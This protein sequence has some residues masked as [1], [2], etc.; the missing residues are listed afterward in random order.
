M[1]GRSRRHHH[2]ALLVCTGRYSHGQQPRVITGTETRCL[3]LGA[4]WPVHLALCLTF[5]HLTPPHIALSRSMGSFQ[6]LLLF[7]AARVTCNDPSLRSSQFSMAQ[8]VQSSHLPPGLHKNRVVTDSGPALGGNPTEACTILNRV[9]GT[10]TQDTSDAG[11]VVTS[12]RIVHH[13]SVDM[14][15]LPTLLHAA[16]EPRGVSS[17]CDR[18]DRSPTSACTLLMPLVSA[19]SLYY[20]PGPVVG[21]HTAKSL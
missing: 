17:I 6:S 3:V 2:Q 14:F 12:T 16:F 11:S 18:L 10:A 9:Q 1:S 8:A 13:F 5:L 15:C 19:I 4:W 20:A 21:L 7:C